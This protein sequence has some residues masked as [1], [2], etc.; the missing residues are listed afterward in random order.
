MV[1]PRLTCVLDPAEQFRQ[2]SVSACGAKVPEGQLTHATLAN[3]NSPAWIKCMG[4]QHGQVHG[5]CG[6]SGRGAL[7]TRAIR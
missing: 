7:Y 5:C 1:A 6:L 3:A 4:A 2:R